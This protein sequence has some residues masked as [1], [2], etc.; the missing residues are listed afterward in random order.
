MKVYNIIRFDSDGNGG[1]KA[2]VILTFADRLKAE[3]RIVH[4]YEQ[5][6]PGFLGKTFSE[7]GLKEWRHNDYPTF[8][9]ITK[10]LLGFNGLKKKILK[11]KL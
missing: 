11:G 8:H 6:N 5:Y 3:E 1:E 7:D 9:V 2:K 4:L 10:T